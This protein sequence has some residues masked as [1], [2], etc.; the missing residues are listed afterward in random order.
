MTTGAWIMLG[1]T[2]AV[3]LWFTASL[4]VRVVRTPPRDDA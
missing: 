4:F 3:I 2:W 1:T